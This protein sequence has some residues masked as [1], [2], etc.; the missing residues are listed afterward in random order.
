MDYFH[1]QNAQLYC[2][3]VPVR[4]LAD[5]FGTP[6]WVYSR[7]TILHHLQ[8]LNEGF[9]ELRPLI[10]YSV[11]ANANLGILKLMAEPGAGFDAV[12]GGNPPR[13]TR[14]GG[15]PA[16]TVFAGVGKTAEEI[17]YGLEKGVLMFNVE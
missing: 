4:A 2:E 6:L 10:C 16:T 15:A 5:Q 14:P 9:A 1:Y 11:K 13:G 8:K 12:P 17:R 7:R 3:E